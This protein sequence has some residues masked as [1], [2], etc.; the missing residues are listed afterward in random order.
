ML[1]DKLTN[2][3]NNPVDIYLFLEKLIKNVQQRK[4]CSG[5]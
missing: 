3:L 4:M 1:F 2:D 5:D